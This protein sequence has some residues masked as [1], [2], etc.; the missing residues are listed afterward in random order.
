M[1]GSFGDDWVHVDNVKGF[2]MT[3][4]MLPSR[5]SDYP[6]DMSDIDPDIDI[7][8]YCD[9]LRKAITN[10]VGHEAGALL[11]PAVVGDILTIAIFG[12]L[13]W[14][15]KQAVVRKLCLILVAVIQLAVA[16]L[17]IVEAAHVLKNFRVSAEGLSALGLGWC[18]DI[19]IIGGAASILASP[20]AIISLVFPP[21]TP[22]IVDSSRTATVSTTKKIPL[23]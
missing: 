16:I 22:V 18:I 7:N 9:E 15:S 20:L 12:L 14:R 23:A 5:C 3:V 17:A 19:L 4:G 8:A 11:V 2:S 10:A 1:A 6:S 13:W 21:A